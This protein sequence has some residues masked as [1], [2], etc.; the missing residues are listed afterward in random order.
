MT[1]S[2]WSYSHMRIYSLNKNPYRNTTT[3][4]IS[5]YEQKS[6]NLAQGFSLKKHMKYLQQ[7]RNS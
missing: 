7:I 2:F 1:K 3:N 6:S 5:I 4:N